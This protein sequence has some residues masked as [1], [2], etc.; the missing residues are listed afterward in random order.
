MRFEELIPKLES[1]CAYQ[2]RC[3]FE[4]QRK[5]NQLAASETDSKKII[6]HLLNNNFFDQFR[7]A[8]SFA[9]GKLRI[10]KWGK[11]KI[12]LALTQKKIDAD[13]IQNAIHSIDNEEYIEIIKSLI[14]RK[15]KDLSRE[16]NDWI[17]KQKLI[18]YLVSKGF[19]YEEVEEFI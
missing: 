17:K 12:K 4:I 15:K 13:T 8:Q 16:E 18:R 2:E 19:S 9:Y 10:N 5:L 11:A 14:N 1:Y 3:L 7:Y 6:V